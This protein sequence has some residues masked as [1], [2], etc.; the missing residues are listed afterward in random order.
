MSL[1]R[2]DYN[3]W[4]ATYDAVDNPLV[5]MSSF[6]VEEAARGWSGA[7]VVELGCG[8]ARNARPI[9]AAGAREYV[10]VDA[11]PEMLERGRARVE[12]D[13]RV[14][15]VVGDVAAAPAESF[16]AAMFCLVLEHFERLDAP[17]AAAARALRQG[18]ELAIFELHPAWWQDGGRAHYVVDGEERALASWPHDEAELARVLPACGLELVGVRSWYAHEAACARSPKLRK[19]LGKPILL[20]ARARR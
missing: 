9:V 11:S 12:G 6:A 14:R 10:G 18:G 7:R 19:R 8:T 13:A 2:D 3:A 1:T 5:A 17:L 15:L 20:E 4:A 16:D